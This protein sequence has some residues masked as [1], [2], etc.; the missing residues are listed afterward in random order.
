[1]KF[2]SL[3]QLENTEWEPYNWL[4]V[5]L[6][7]WLSDKVITRDASGA[8]KEGCMNDNCF[9]NIFRVAMVE[10]EEDW[11][12]WERWQAINSRLIDLLAANWCWPGFTVV[13]RSDINVRC[14]ALPAIPGLLVSS[15]VEV[16]VGKFFL[17]TI[18]ECRLLWKKQV[19]W[20][21]ILF[22]C[23]LNS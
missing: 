15:L 20:D 10:S 5:W 8:R 14:T 23:G 1:M 9:Y 7:E 22:P 18:N 19:P 11:E 6:T 2:S 13:I 3:Y 16:C 17:S 12:E 4:T 21:L